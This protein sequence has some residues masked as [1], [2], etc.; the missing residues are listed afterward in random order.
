MARRP[1]A[2]KTV[3]EQAVNK[4][5]KRLKSIPDPTFD[6]VV[7][8]GSLLLDLNIS[9]KRRRG[10]G[11]PFGILMEIFG[12]SGAG[13]TA[14]LAEICGSAATRGWTYDIKDPEARIDKEYSRIYGV[15]INKDNYSRPDTVTA[16]FN[17]LWE[18]LT[19]K[20]GAKQFHVS[21]IDSL[22]ALST[23]LELEKGDKMGMRRAKEFSEATRKTCRMIANNNWLIPCT[24]QIRQGD[25]GETTPGGEAIPFYSS[26]RLRIS[27]AKDWQITRS[28][29]LHGVDHTKVIGIKSKVYVKKSSIDEPY[30]DCEIFIVFGYGVH[31]IMT[32]LQ[33]VKEMTK[34]TKYNAV[35]R[36][37]GIMEQAVFHVE[38]EGLEEPLREEVMKLWYEL[39]DRFKTERKPKMRF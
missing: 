1:I 19:K 33:Y 36:E 39:E 24:N 27:P 34:N 32:N 25:Y 4:I 20:T 37:Y 23:N 8:S 6:N 31:D 11:I 30:R 22:A 10:G 15:E 9:G 3:A 17:E 18:G 12:P 26:L 16:V 5:H 7:S 28:R 21:G 35:D 29:S 38:K 14:L 2:T 13:K